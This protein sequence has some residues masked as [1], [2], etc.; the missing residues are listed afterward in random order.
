M[1]PNF[2]IVL[3]NH[4]FQVYYFYRRWEL[5][6]QMHPNVDVTLLAPAEYEWYKD[7]DYT[8]DGAKKLQAKVKDEGNFHIRQFRAVYPKKGDW[9]SPDFKDIFLDIKP[10]IIYNVGTHQQPS[11]L[12]IISLV[13]KYLP[14]TKVMCF[15]M[16]GPCHDLKKPVMKGS[17]LHYLRRCWSYLRQK[18]NLNYVNKNVDAI[19]CHYPDA[20]DS[21]R[22]EGYKGAL[23]MQTQV[24]VNEEWFHEDA[25]ARRE[26]REKYNLGDS[27]VFGSASRFTTDKGIDD[28][29][30]ALPKA[31]NWKYLMMGK[32][33]EEDN[34]RLSDLVKKNGLEDKVIMTGFVDWYDMA[35]YW[36]AVDCA[37]HVPRT[38]EKWVETFS[39]AAVQP[40]ITKKPVIGNTSGSVPYQIGFEEMIVPEGDI[41]ALAAKIQ[42][43]I[44]HSE[45]A[46]SMGHKM[47]ERAH[48]SFSVLH[49]DNM[50]YD[51]ILDVL[52]GVYD[53]NK[54]DMAKYKNNKR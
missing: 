28:I 13:K 39:L 3:I 25:E 38:T 10:D 45:E 29:L 4:S 48:N 24:G 43:A 22:K 11:L 34:K 32:G 42:W 26:I 47:Y 16:R 33:S 15:S 54:I 14:E 1:E 17:P 18:H 8:Y 6:A 44:L 20:F 46:S 50:F 30:N 53:D 12:Q 21:F 9:T 27:F 40:Q 49:L 23:Y 41:K 2:K 51:T 19:F 35:K 36:N 52:H 37:I 5:F 31:G 7:K